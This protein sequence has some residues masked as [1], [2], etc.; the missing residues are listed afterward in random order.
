MEPSDAILQFDRPPGLVGNYARAILSRRER[1][2]PAGTT[3]PHLE[4]RVGQVGINPRHLE[5]YR[6]ICRFPA[7]GQLPVTY[8]HV[9]AISL[10]VAVMAQPRFM[11][12]L[13]GLVHLS[14]EITWL[15]PLPEDGSYGLRCWL[16]GHRETDR[17]QEFDLH[18]ELLDAEGPAWRERS[19]VLARKVGGGQQAARAARAALKAPKPAPGTI[20]QSVPFQASH[21]LSRAYALNSGD[22]NPIHLAD[23][24]ARWFGF[25][26]ALAHG[27]WTMGCSLAALGPDLTR[28]PCRIP[29][30]FKLPVFLPAAVQ[31]E[32]WHEEQ[33]WPFVLRDAANGR[34]HLAGSV[35]RL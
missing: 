10:Q 9:L 17:G 6:A 2:L 26:K 4:G 15:R 24:T 32:H 8:P 11:L 34:P 14:N 3:I 29:V 31:L 12:R 22:L 18:T 1:L 28:S 21:A 13:L 27:M 23:V 25:D 35:E 19:T 33:A 30:E 7:D 16:E 20:V 5:K